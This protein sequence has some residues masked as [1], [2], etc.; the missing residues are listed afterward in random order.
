[1]N[2]SSSDIVTAILGALQDGDVDAVI[3]LVAEDI[4]YSNVS[5]PT[6]RGKAKF[7]QAF[8]TY[9]RH[10][11]TFEVV[12]HRMAENGTT[13]LTERTDALIAGPFRMQLWVCG[14]FEV[15]DGHVTLWRDYFDWR[16]ATLAMLRGLVGLVVRPLRT[17]LPAPEVL[18]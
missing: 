15:H 14:I 17:T 5:L 6:I 12:V 2:G 13:V 9:F 11:L 16:N 10:H 1:M 7:A 18:T 4:V 8:R 3:D